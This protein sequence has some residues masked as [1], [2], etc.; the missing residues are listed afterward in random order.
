[1]KKAVLFSFQNSTNMTS[2]FSTQ[3][4]R[5]QSLKA[6]SWCVLEGKG[7]NMLVPAIHSAQ[8]NVAAIDPETSQ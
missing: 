8:Y 1:M 3:S 2:S 7:F 4:R 5:R 6:L